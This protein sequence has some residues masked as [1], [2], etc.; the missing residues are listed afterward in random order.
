MARGTTVYTQAVGS[1][2]NYKALYQNLS[3]IL[4]QASPRTAD[5]GQ[6]NWAGI[7]TESTVIRDYEIFALGGSL[8]A[9]APV[10]IRVD[11]VGSS[12]GYAQVTVGTATDG[13][14]NL[15]GL[16][17]AAFK[18][19]VHAI[20]NQANLSAWAASDGSSYFTFHYALDPVAT[21]TD[22]LG[23][24]VV[25]RTRD[26]TGAPTAA[27]FHVWRWQANTATTTVGF[28]G[29]YRV[30]GAGSQPVNPDYTFGTF[31]PD[32]F[33]TTTGLVGSTAYCWPAFT[34][35]PLSP[36]GASKA[37]LFGYPPDFPRGQAITVNHYGEAQTYVSLGDSV[38]NVFPSVNNSGAVVSTKTL[39]PLIRWD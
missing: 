8:Q 36:G 11:Y 25:E 26:L 24:F 13:A 20:T 31:V 29:Q 16:T 15:S 23:I 22:G 17:V 27:G 9:T 32:I 19:Q 6:V 34:Y 21:G 5:T 18:L 38:S 12:S 35:T 2:A 4:N 10:Y 28:G 1:L 14:G 30:F 3:V 37:L 33:N 39:M 7:A